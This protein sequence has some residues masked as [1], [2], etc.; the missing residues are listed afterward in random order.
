MTKKKIRL[1]FWTLTSLVLMVLFLVFLVYPIGGLLKEAFFKDGAFSLDAFA[2]FFSKK[3]YY[4]TIGHSTKIG[5]AVTA[6]SLLIGIPFSYFYSFYELKWKKVIF[7]LCL[8]CTMSAPFIGA[9]AWILLLGNS[10]IITGLLKASGLG[11]ISIYGFG[12]IVFVQVLKLF[13]LVVIYMNG[14]FRDIDNSLLE[15]A[16]SMGCKGVERFKRVIMGLTMPTILAAGHQPRPVQIILFSS[17]IPKPIDSILQI[18]FFKC[19]NRYN[20]PFI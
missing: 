19:R 9:Y 1:D 20:S 15:A 3:H 16:E 2:Q 6:V 4:E 8:L 13:P 10:G 11:N 14:A 7:V 12:G 17:F 18:Y 5:L